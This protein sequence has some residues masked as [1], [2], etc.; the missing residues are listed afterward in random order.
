VN[1]EEEEYKDSAVIKG[2][3]GDGGTVLEELADRPL[4]RQGATGCSV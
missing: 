3:V 4:E 2:E 1:E